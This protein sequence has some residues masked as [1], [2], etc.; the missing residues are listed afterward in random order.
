MPYKPTGSWWQRLWQALCTALVN[1]KQRQGEYIDRDADHERFE[2]WR[3]DLDWG[4][5]DAA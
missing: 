2:R 1:L 4:G 3:R 5:D